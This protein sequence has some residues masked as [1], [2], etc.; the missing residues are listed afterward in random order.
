MIVFP[1][2]KVNL[3][4]RILGRNEDN[5][6]DMHTY[7]IP[8]ELCDALEIVPSGNG[9]SFTSSG[10]DKV[11]VADDNLCFKSYNLLAR[12][13][14]LK[15]VRIHLHKMIPVSAGLGGGA[16][17]VAFTMSLLRRI[18]SLRICDNELESLASII[19]DDAPFFITNRPQLTTKLGHATH[20]FL[21]IKRYWVVIVNATDL[22]QNNKITIKA[23]NKIEADSTE[24][25]ASG[26]LLPPKDQIIGHENKW[27][28]ILPNDLEEIYYHRYPVL[29]DIRDAMYASGAFYASLAGTGFSVYGLFFEKVNLADLFPDMY[30]WQ[31]RTL[32]Y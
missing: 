13:Y 3:G 12:Y 15:K 6:P 16:A 11:S 4:L 26:E 7:K 19:R 18:N 22:N 23:S 25:T 1:N 10:I 31:G 20:D 29:K 32:C 17:N 24:V 2:A 28:D 30:V 14:K 5:T 21:H 8:V 9:E 27:R